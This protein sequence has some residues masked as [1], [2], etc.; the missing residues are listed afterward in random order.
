MTVLKLNNLKISYNQ[1]ECACEYCSGERN[2]CQPQRENVIF[3]V[4]Y[5]IINIRLFRSTVYTPPAAALAPAPAPAPTPAPTPAPGTHPPIKRDQ[6][7]LTNAA[8][9]K[10]V[11]KKEVMCRL[12]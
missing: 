5:F 2:I 1:Q 4:I 12:V 7:H 8:V 10:K 9:K 6:H 11:S 3:L